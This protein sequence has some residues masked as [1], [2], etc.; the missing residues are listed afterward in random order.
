MLAVP[1]QCAVGLGGVRD[2]AGVVEGALVAVA[3]GRESDECE[4]EGVEEDPA[5]RDPAAG[6]GEIF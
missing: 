1:V 2:L 3:D 4:P 6:H 5:L